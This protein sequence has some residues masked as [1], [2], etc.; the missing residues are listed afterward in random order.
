MRSALIKLREGRGEVFNHLAEDSLQP[1]KENREEEEGNSLLQLLDPLS[2]KLKRGSCF[3]IPQPKRKRSL[4]CEDDPLLEDKFKRKRRCPS[5]ES[6]NS[7]DAE[8]NRHFR[9]IKRAPLSPPKKNQDGRMVKPTIVRLRPRGRPTK[10]QSSQTSRSG[11]TPE[12][13]KS[14]IVE[15]V[16]GREEDPA[17][18]SPLIVYEK[19]PNKVLPQEPVSNASQCTITRPLSARITST[20]SSTA[21]PTTSARSA[22][23]KCREDLAPST[24][25][26]LE[27]PNNLLTSDACTPTTSRVHWLSQSLGSVENPTKNPWSRGCH[28]QRY[29][30]FLF[31]CNTVA[32]EHIIRDNIM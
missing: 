8:L 29:K 2:N 3:E 27:T 4:P 12:L 22:S 25:R 18:D 19:N 9:P 7:I 26:L 31:M 28:M 23:L 11:K 5:E 6:N 30:L 32:Q 15:N 24:P 20:R 14:P 10:V 21:S 13:S 17:D 16:L 1:E